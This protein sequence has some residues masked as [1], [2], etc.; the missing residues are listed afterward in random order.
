MLINILL[1]A[2]GFAG[3]GFAQVLAGQN[4]AQNL[5]QNRA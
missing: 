3:G 5:G 1:D 2:R 4:R